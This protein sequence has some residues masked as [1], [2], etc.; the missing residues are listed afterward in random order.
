MWETPE[1]QELWRT[2]YQKRKA[3][4]LGSWDTTE[5]EME[6]HLNAKRDGELHPYQSTG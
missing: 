6:S 5:T 2:R 1:L 4:L 3:V